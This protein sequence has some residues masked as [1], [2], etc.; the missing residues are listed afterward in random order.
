MKG[1]KEC[2]NRLVA[3]SGLKVLTDVAGHVAYIV[4]YQEAYNY[5][6]VMSRLTMADLGAELRG[7]PIILLLTAIS[8]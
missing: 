7:R 3:P 1:V 4:E 6:V 5:M 8:S 2:L